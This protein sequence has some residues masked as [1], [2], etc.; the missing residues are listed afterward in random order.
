MYKKVIYSILFL[1]LPGLVL[2]S[3]VRAA[4][5]N[6]VGWWKFDEGSGTTAEDSSG[7]GNHG[8][9][10]NA[11]WVTGFVD[12]ALNINGTGYVDVPAKAW[13]TIQRQVTVA[14]WAYGDPAGQP[15]NHFT[16]AAF[17]D[18]AVGDSRV[19]SCHTPWGN[20]NVYFDTGGTAPASGYD[21]IYKAATP[22]EYEGRWQHWAFTK[23]ATTGQQRIYLNGVLWHSGTGLTRTMGGAAVTVFTIGCGPSYTQN[24]AGMIDDFRLYDRV[25]TEAE[26]K[27][28]AARPKA[29]DP[30]PADGA[31]GVT[32]PVFQWTA[33]T[34]AVRHN[35]Y[36]GTAP[37]ALEFMGPQPFAVYY[38]APGLVPGT[39]YYWRVDEVE[40]DLVT[41]HTGDV[42]SFTAAPLT[43]YKP[44]PW[45]GAKWVDTEADLGWSAGATAQKHD[46]Y[47]G[48][49][50][51]DVANGTGGTFQVEQ[52]TLTYEPGTLAQDTTYYWRIDEI[53]SG[54]TKYPGAVWSFT[55]IGPDAGVKGQY[56]HHSGSTPPSPPESAFQTLVLT[57]VD[58]GINFSWGDPGSPDPKVNVDD[59]S[60]RWVAD[61]E[62]PFSE[63]YTF[64]TYTDDGV[65]LWL[66]GQLII[67]NWTDHGGTWNQ[68][69]PIQLT[70]GQT[71]SI[72]M[73][74]YERAGGAT[75]QLH[76]SSPSIQRQV[77]PAGPLSL[78][79]RAS[80]PNPANGAV[81]VKDTPTLRWSAG[82][83]AAKHNV[84][85]G[86]DATAVADATTASTGIYRGQ[87]NLDVTSYTPT[88]APLAWDT[89]YYWRIDEVNGVDLWKGNV[90][91]FTTANF[92]VVDDFEDYD[93]WCNRV[94]Y[95]WTDGWGYSAD[96]TCGVA[97]Y[98]G[99]G[100]GSG[101]ANAQA[102]FMETSIVHA[103]SQS[104]PF[105]YDNSGA[106]GKARYSETQRQWA[107]PQD[108]TQN[109][110]KALT[111]W[112]YGDPANTVEQLYV[113]VEDNAGQVK[114]V[115]HPEP[116]RI[117][118]G[119]WQ[120]WN[121]ELTQFAGVNL[122]MVKKMYI[123]VGNRASP[124]AGGSGKLYID[125]IRVYPSRCVP[126]KPKPAA[127]LSGNC[128]VD[129]A[130]VEIVADQWLDSGF[131]ITPVN[132]GTANLAA[133]WKFDG[134]AQDS[135]GKA[136]HGIVG[137]AAEWV[138]GV[139]GNALR[140][141]G[142]STYVDIGDTIV[143][144][145]FTLALWL[146]YDTLREGGY[147]AVMHTDAWTT[148]SVHVHMRSGT[149]LFNFD[150]NGGIGATT[151]TALDAGEWYHLVGSVDTS[152]RV[153]KV[154]VDGLL[155]G[156]NTSGGAATPSIGLLNIGA[157]NDSDRFFDGVMD[158]FR[159]YDRAL[160]AAEVAWLAGLTSPFSIPADLHMDDKIDFKDF[161]KL[162]D[163][164]LEEILWP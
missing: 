96:P 79:L 70:V 149:R 36:L 100:T 10:T 85:F 30:D 63:A 24:Y 46:V 76:W 64:W 71:Y 161:A 31:D 117:Q 78:P 12:G 65:M 107:T 27:I 89:T 72:E 144:G 140:F 1:L 99:N 32:A 29:Y 26:L 98:G 51:A 134:D 50:Q 147:N 116:A 141:D 11:Q 118:I 142:L 159:I 73:W 33:G 94:F 150:V 97:A 52:Y 115:N 114:V 56:Y 103:G 75:A 68:S 67:S 112:F 106:G 2:P 14:F 19:A 153:A 6:L 69:Q 148:G 158:D 48:T 146:K 154:Y 3:T 136:H 55:T 5:P 80:R 84:Y 131:V 130:D 66:N 123:G 101:I 28:L 39:T 18:A 91:S 151:N 61:L 122:K 82:E 93:D 87:Q 162:A 104:V 121:I 164:W 102:P 135:S 92:I 41:I 37:D 44:D 43:A 60:A 133:H 4:D 138:A 156:T 128:I 108:W 49:N 38:H 157:W 22:A 34:F 17:Q 145:S 42:W 54:G 126:S 9:I 53:D 105:S 163:S 120:E 129:Y 57:R 143:E 111:L 7:F 119:G 40:A 35:F 127:D 47:F 15:Q 125:D 81:D 62:V 25:L 90:W 8:T 13:S 86:T 95:T 20:G 21:R 77:I 59:F 139:S 152:A 109:N 155:D 132:P 45:D 23:N 124:T 88:E 58:P 110:V 16:F 74:Y 113:A 160:S 137:G 83:K